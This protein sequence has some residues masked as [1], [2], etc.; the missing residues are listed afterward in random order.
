MLFTDISTSFQLLFTLILPLYNMLRWDLAVVEDYLGE[1]GEMVLTQLVLHLRT[2]GQ[3]WMVEGEQQYL[4]AYQAVLA[5]LSQR[6]E[7]LTQIS[8]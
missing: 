3:P 5:I 8:V 7:E 2:V 6:L 4:L 1:E